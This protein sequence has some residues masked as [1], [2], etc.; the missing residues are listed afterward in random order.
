MQY[1]A[2]SFAAPLL[3]AYQPV[4]GVVTRREADRHETHAVDPVLAMVLQPAWVRV[5]SLA[6]RIRP[7]QRGRLSVYLIYIVL[8]LVAL[9]FYLLAMVG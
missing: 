8:T 5:R 6:D 9:L 7:I 2:S 3:A 1:T 4:A